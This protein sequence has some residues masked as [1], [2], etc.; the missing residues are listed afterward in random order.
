VRLASACAALVLLSVTLGGTAEWHSLRS[1][2][3]QLI[4]NA[5]VR[6]LRDAALRFE[7]FREIVTRIGTE[8]PSPDGDAPVTIVV[9][10][11][12]TSFEPFMPRVNDRRLPAAG[13]FV[14]GPDTT[15]IA[16][17]LNNADQSFRE[18]FH[19]YSHLLLRRVFPDAPLW[20]NEGLAEY[21]STL[22]ITSSRSAL[23]G[24]PV[25]AHVRLLRQGSMALA[26]LFEVTTDSPEYT[27]ATVGRLRL[28]AQSWAVVHHA[29][30]GWRNGKDAIT[31]LARMLAA[32]SA[33]DESVRATYGVPLADV[34]Q[35]VRAY[36]RQSS[37]KAIAFTFREDLVTRL[38]GGAIEISD[39]EADAWLGD[40]LGQ[41]GRVDEG[42]Q[43]LKAAIE[44]QPDLG[45]AHAA[46]GLLL[47]RQNRDVE[48]ADHFGN[49]EAIGGTDTERLL[50]RRAT[51]PRRGFA[52]L[53]VG[54]RA[55]AV[56][57]PAG[58]R[59]FLRITL[60]DERRSFG[61]LE[62]LECDGDL[63]EFVMWTSEGVLRARASFGDVQVVNYRDGL[64][65]VLCGP[66]PAPLPALLTWLPGTGTAA[67][68]VAV[69]FVPDG[70]VP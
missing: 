67:R 69:E 46:L 68:A 65:D 24:I 61:L 19:E 20:F 13:M 21:Y 31:A 17:R 23:V 56:A 33:A 37:Y 38:A 27:D 16:V 15:Y 43:K 30:H 48:A 36:V 5:S 22:R 11:D 6:D 18:M 2:H 41:M 8:R 54:G 58:A 49:A 52:A 70:F 12:A 4:G 55:P 32:G 53:N 40:L 47:L 9:F 42:V 62:A 57:R 60:A 10:R 25:P 28:Y 64:G 39:A 3:F 34:E 45:R 66:Q 29:F 35:Q 44:R 1:Q 63:A 26:R 51:V 7:Q 50:A 14:E 59:P